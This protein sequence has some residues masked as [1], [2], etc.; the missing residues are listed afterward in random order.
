LRE[1]S[2]RLG[3]DE[4]FMDIEDIRG[5]TAFPQVLR[6]AVQ[7][8]AV[9][10]V[11]IGPR[12]LTAAGLNGGRRLEDPA[13]FVRQEILGAFES[14][15]RVIPV[16]LDGAKM[17]AAADLPEPLSPLATLNALELS[18]RHWHEDVD[19][20]FD[21]IHEA[22]YARGTAL[23]AGTAVATDFSPIA[24]T[25]TV[26]RWIF[27]TFF[28]LGI[29]L[30]VVAVATAILD[31]RLFPSVSGLLA[32]V[33]TTVGGVPLLIGLRRTLRFR[34]LR[35]R[36]KPIVTSFLRVDHIASVTV[37]GRNPYVIVS[38]WRNPVSDRL[39]EFRSPYVWEDPTSAAS[40]RMI[41][42]VIDPDDFGNYL[43][44]LSFLADRK[45]SG[46][47]G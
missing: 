5:G 31:M 45:R 8:A 29:A 1:L 11:L 39:V 16:L 24:R 19:R 28:L 44:D 23:A 9:T 12:W 47:S 46:P 4:V 43:M 32:A 15:A 42:V 34:H 36:G 22:I 18:N 40:K 33:F 13:D 14:G 35:V 10:L 20:L 26:A 38:Q 37:Q 21:Q 41:T 3:S 17:P 2:D 27:G 6:E 25:P 7:R 30:A